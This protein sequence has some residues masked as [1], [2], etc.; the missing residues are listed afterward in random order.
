MKVEQFVTF[1]LCN[2]TEKPSNRTGSIKIEA[3]CGLQD[4][5]NFLPLPSHSHLGAI[6][7]LFKMATHP[8]MPRVLSGAIAYGVHSQ[9]KDVTL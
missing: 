6:L 3:K 5:T 1:D 8:I 7:W 4:D 2:D 9:G